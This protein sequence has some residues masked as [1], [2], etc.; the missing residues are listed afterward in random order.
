MNALANEISVSWDPFTLDF[1]PD[2]YAQGQSHFQAA[3]TFIPSTERRQAL[4]DLYAFCRV[5]DDIADRKDLSPDHRRSLIEKV[6]DWIRSGVSMG[7]PFWDRFL[8][9]RIRYGV[10]NAP[11][12]G[13]LNGVEQ[14]IERKQLRFE[15]WL[16][17]DH[18]VYGVACCVGEATLA[19][20][21]AK[22]DEDGRLARTYSDQMGKCLQYLNIMRDL[23]EDRSNDRIYVPQEFLKLHGWTDLPP[24]P[25]RQK[26]RDELYRR[27]LLFRANAK[28]Y[29]WRCLP[30]ELMA[31]IYLKGAKKYW[32]S[33]STQ[34]LN[35]F[36]KCVA[37]I[38]I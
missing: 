3:F 34:R 31:R 30:A 23:E 7:H 20:L 16:E 9:E 18:Y 10:V 28:P 33:G 11:L 12:E 26:I 1:R 8:K 2:Q 24:E 5:V 25:A 4:N 27:A 14:D 21:G 38:G 17:L 36:E 29:S 32:R 19:I 22:G 37:L 15:S 13:I 35:K 6:R